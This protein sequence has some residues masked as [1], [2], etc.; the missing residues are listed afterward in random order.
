MFGFLLTDTSRLFRQYFERM[1]TE[2]G[3]G[4][5]PGEIRALGYVIRFRGSRQAL[6]AERMGVEPMTLSAYLDR[7]ESR[8]LIQRTTDTSDR[9][10]KLIEPTEEA[11]AVMRA[12]DPLFT[13]IY[14]Q[15]TQGLDADEMAVLARSLEK[16]RA[17]L[18]TD[19]Q[20]K[21][22]FN[23]ADPACAATRALPEEQC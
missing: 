2:N 1:V 8:G 14:Q 9:R 20:I 3:F 17:N 4:L 5:T 22:P 13:R 6:L 23:L 7:L 10:A 16:L 12:L 15:L 11:Y 21:A 18:T 19:P